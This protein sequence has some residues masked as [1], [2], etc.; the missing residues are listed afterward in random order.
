MI[1]IDFKMLKYKEYNE[2]LKKYREIN[3]IR[4]FVYIVKPTIIIC[5]YFKVDK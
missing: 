3:Y 2:I 4:F 5:M 1:F